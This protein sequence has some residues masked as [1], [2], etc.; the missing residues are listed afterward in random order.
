MS[1]DFK[2]VRIRKAT[3]ASD[4]VHGIH[5]ARLAILSLNLVLVEKYFEMIRFLDTNLQ[6]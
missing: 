6:I 1:A 4:T 2:A 3:V 5:D